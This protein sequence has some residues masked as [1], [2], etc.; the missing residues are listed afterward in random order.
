MSRP[1][2]CDPLMLRRITSTN[3]QY[4]FPVLPIAVF[5]AQR[6]R[7]SDRFSMSHTRDEMCRIALDAHPSAAAIA[8]LAPPEFVVHEPLIDLNSRR[9]ARD[10]SDQGFPV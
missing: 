4:L 10:H 7:R 9:N 2:R 5:D 3:R 6:D 8:L 1:G